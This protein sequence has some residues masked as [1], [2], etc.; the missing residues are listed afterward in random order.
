[1]NVF[2]LC[3]GRCGSKAFIEACSH[4]TNWTSGHETKAKEVQQNHPPSYKYKVNG[5][6]KRLIYPDN[7]IEIDC[8]LTW[9]LGLLDET[10]GDNAFYVNLTRN[11]SRC[12]LSWVERWSS[13]VSILYWWFRAVHQNFGH[14]TKHKDKK[15]PMRMQFALEYV[16]A[17]NALIRMFLKDKIHTMSFPIEDAADLFPVFWKWIGAEGDLDAALAVFNRTAN[18]QTQYKC[19]D[20]GL[21]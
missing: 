14:L 6:Y 21:I 17:A 7:H 12:A 16:D 13:P 20:M 15:R 5:N 9:F 8:R 4:I 11:P 2:V 1:M 19:H 3:S 18:Q 10:H